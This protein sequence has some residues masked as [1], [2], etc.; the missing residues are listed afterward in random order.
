[1]VCHW[2]KQKWSEIIILIDN[3]DNDTVHFNNKDNN[4]Y[5]T[6]THVIDKIDNQFCKIQRSILTATTIITI[7]TTTTNAFVTAREKRAT[8]RY[9]Y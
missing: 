3:T 5:S 4:I 1:M 7:N 9:Q 6:V 8:I 2:L